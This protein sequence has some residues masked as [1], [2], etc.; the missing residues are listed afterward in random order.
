MDIKS[1]EF[2][3]KLES[4]I[5]LSWIFLLIFSE[6]YLIFDVVVEYDFFP[7]ISFTSDEDSKVISID[8]SSLVVILFFEI[9]GENPLDSGMNWVRSS[10][11]LPLLS[12]KNS[13][14]LCNSLSTIFECE[15][16]ETSE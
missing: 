8:L 14:L 9:S 5:E 13:E 1:L 16:V 12:V 4:G 3:I 2:I 7:A 15:P 6:L 11:I 10:I